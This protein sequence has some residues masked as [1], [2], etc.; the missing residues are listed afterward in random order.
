[1]VCP[2]DDGADRADAAVD[3]V[4]DPLPDP[5]VNSDNPADSVDSADYVDVAV[6]PTVSVM[7]VHF[8]PLGGTPPA[9]R[10]ER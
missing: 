2:F 8:L 5:P 7:F 4:V 1:M 9:V 3:S 6:A 10:L